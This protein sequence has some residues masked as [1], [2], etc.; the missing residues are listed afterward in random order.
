MN[1]LK[2][3]LSLNIFEHLDI[4]HLVVMGTNNLLFSSVKM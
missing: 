3:K 2:L 4:E 1:N